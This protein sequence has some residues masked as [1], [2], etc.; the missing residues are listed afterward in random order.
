MIRRFDGR[1]FLIADPVTGV[2]LD[3][4]EIVIDYPPNGVI[5]AEGNIR[6][7]GTVASPSS[8]A[9][10]KALGKGHALTI[11]SNKTIYVEGNVIKERMAPDAGSG[12]NDL[13]RYED[14]GVALLAH[15]H[16]CVNTTQF[17]RIDTIFGPYSEAIG[18]GKPYVPY[19]V[20]M[21][22]AQP[23]TGFM[24]SFAE[25]RRFISQGSAVNPSVNSLY[26]LA[27]HGAA[28]PPFIA[29]ALSYN[30]P[31]GNPYYFL[32]NI[33][34]AEISLTGWGPLAVMYNPDSGVYP[35]L[36][37]DTLPLWTDANG[38][39]KFEGLSPGT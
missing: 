31:D 7:R 11:V 17:T 9:G 21:S 13:A 15:D 23:P 19:D 5:F 3:P 27:E 8:T 34:S 6:V 26:L 10:G 36:Q 33:V 35:N 28:R 29:F 25:G 39:Y 22:G 2:V 1:S 32:N 37:M 24:A 20:Q 18:A 16:V 38:D 4:T 12:S 14:T 30:T